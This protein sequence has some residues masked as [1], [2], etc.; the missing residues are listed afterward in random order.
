MQLNNSYTSTM[1][2]DCLFLNVFVP[3]P[4]VCKNRRD[5]AVIVFIFSFGVGATDVRDYGPHLLLSECV[6]LVSLQYR[7]NI[8]G[9]LPLALH[10]YSGNMGMK[11][12]QL[13]MKWVNRHI[14]AF[15]G[16]PNKITLMG[17][18]A[19]GS[20]VSLHRLNP[21]SRSYFK[22]AYIMSGSIFPYYAL[23]ETNN[24][25][26]LIL[27]LA[28]NQSIDIENSE[29]LI[30]YLQTVDANYLLN[31]TS[32]LNMANNIFT[33]SEPWQPCIECELME[34]F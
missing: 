14:S 12:Q 25:T 2:E 24:K 7:V 21:K 3:E 22:R 33:H 9:F 20:S 5:I 1:S 18:S 29:Q 28:K 6:I 4:S 8:F 32:T 11:D 13:A 27:E 16:N 34:H 15:G 10:E 19:G 31:Q 26:D 17:H 30:D 23:S